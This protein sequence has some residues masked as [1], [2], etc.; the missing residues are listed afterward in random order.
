MVDVMTR[1][2]LIDT[3]DDPRQNIEL[4]VMRRHD[5]PQQPVWPAL[6]PDDA[7]RL[8]ILERVLARL[9]SI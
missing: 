6:D 2:R 5:A 7:D 9:R 3:P 1:H 8:P 4:P